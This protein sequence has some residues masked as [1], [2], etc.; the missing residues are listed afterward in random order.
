MLVARVAIQH[1]LCVGF[2]CFV[3]CIGFRLIFFWENYVVRTKG[4]ILKIEAS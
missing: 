1:S 4:R 3:L 2:S